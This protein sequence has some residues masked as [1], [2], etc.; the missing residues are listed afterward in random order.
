MSSHESNDELVFADQSPQDAAPTR[1]ADPSSP[2]WKVIVA[3]DEE[4]VH[5]I[6]GIVLEDF[7]YE[8]I[9]LNILHA[10]SGQEALNMVKE[11]PD[12][13][14]ILL[15]VVMENEQAGLDV[16]RDIRSEL[17]NK[18]TRIILRTGQ[19][20]YAPER[21]VIRQYDINDYKQKT[22]LTA[23]KLFTTIT[24]AIRSYN[25]LMELESAKKELQRAITAAHAA[26]MAKSQLLTNISHEFRTPLN[27][28][29]GMSGLLLKSGLDEQEQE[30][31]RTIQDSGNELLRI[32]NNLLTV[33]SL[34]INSLTLEHK[35]FSLREAVDSALTNVQ[36][37]MQDKKLLSFKIVDEDVPDD[38]MGDRHNLEQIII[39][40]LLN[41][42]R[43]TDEGHITL[44]VSP[45]STPMPNQPTLPPSMYSGS[46]AKSQR[47]LVSI[48][49][50][51]SGIP[52]E[53]QDSLFSPFALAEN[54]MYKSGSGM[55]LGL[56]ICKALVEKMGGVIWLEST[57]GEG[58]TFYFIVELPLEESLDA[59]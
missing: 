20:G 45:F 22:E 51:G 25:D 26:S 46:L 31:S 48:A 30:Y 19:P 7:T 5:K 1:V 17:N 36:T 23:Q 41:G 24:T 12:T 6:T 50:T 37:Q 27:G 11:N 32:L 2:L 59:I 34:D 55:G 47:V 8:G 10:Y 3:D 29:I 58:T 56:S 44:T 28:I 18:M 54:V 57:L 49:D 43:S 9:P 14:L 39:N 40:L 42:I 21:E 13:A 53:K 38:F 15:D 52:Q 33:T 35:P 4:E 16:A